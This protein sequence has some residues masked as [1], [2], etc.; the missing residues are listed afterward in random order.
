VTCFTVRKRYY[1]GNL[2]SA[3]ITYISAFFVVVGSFVV[4]AVPVD[5]FKGGNSDGYDGARY[6]QFVGKDRFN[7]GYLDGHDRNVTNGVVP[8]PQIMIFILF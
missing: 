5:R 2:M 7:G 8:P 1:L 6:A 4:S 3:K